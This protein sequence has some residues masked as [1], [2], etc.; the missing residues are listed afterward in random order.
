MR[1][2]NKLVWVAVVILLSVAIFVGAGCELIRTPTLEEY[3][4]NAIT[5]LE[6]YAESKGVRN[7]TPENWA[8]LQS[9]V[10]TGVNNINAAT[11]KAGVRTA[12]AIAK[13]AVGEVEIN[14][15][16]FEAEINR[17]FSLREMAFGNPFITVINNNTELLL[18]NEESLQYRFDGTW[19]GFNWQ[20]FFNDNLL[21]F[22]DDFYKTYQLIL[23]EFWGGV[24]DYTVQN[25]NY[26]SNM[27]NVDL[28]RQASCSGEY[29]NAEYG[30]CARP[31]VAQER[32]LILKIPRISNYFN[33][34]F[35]LINNF[36]NCF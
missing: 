36:V 2:K 30:M 22:E 1:T 31:S 32:L 3:Q 12:L 5:T 34:D 24:L 35:Y 21:I 14:T 4:A 19:N 6:A 26:H 23:I 25:V 28:L 13:Q 16:D 11:D 29:C 7:Y 18:W 27:L 9:H 20:E 15:L 8:L 33:V 17:I 10:T